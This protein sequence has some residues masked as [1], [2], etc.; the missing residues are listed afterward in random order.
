MV[1]HDSVHAVYPE[2]SHWLPKAAS[3][4]ALEWSRGKY[5]AEHIAAEIFSGAVALWLVS[6]E[7]SGNTIGFIT[8]KLAQRAEGHSLIIVHTA[9]EEGFLEEAVKCC[10][11]RLE[12]HAKEYKCAGIEIIGRPGWTKFIGQYGFYAVPQV[13]YVK[14]F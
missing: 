4:Q 14:K 6:D 2:I 12:A 11:P 7:A 5:R 13:N 1:P 10:M 9:G 3:F 8:T